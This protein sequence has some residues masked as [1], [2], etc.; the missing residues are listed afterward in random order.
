MKEQQFP[1][2]FI[3]DDGNSYEKSRFVIVQVPYEGTLVYE[4]GASYGPAA[5]VQASRWLEYYDE[6][7]DSE[8]AMLGICTLDA[9]KCKEKAEDVSEQVREQVKQIFSDN[10]FPIVLGGEHS[11]SLGAIKAASEKYNDLTVLH[12][13]AHADLREGK[14]THQ[15]VMKKVHE[16]GVKH[17]SVGI[18]CISK[19]ESEFVRKE[20]IPVFYAKDKLD[21]KEVLLQLSD[22]VYITLDVDAFDPSIMPATGTPEPGGLLWYDMLKLLKVVSEKN[23][24]GADVVELSPKEGLHYCD[25]TAAKLVY[26]IVAYHQSLSQN[27]LRSSS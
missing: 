15:S 14:L 10:K 25:Y 26:K 12:I 11:I 22:N 5:I 2:P 8:P 4:K 19:D 24:V 6:E 21:I 13:D 27:K 9:V 7:I 20:N 18:R 17:V 23:V 1:N 3:V 16:L